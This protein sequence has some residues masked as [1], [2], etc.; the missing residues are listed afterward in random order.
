MAF[1]GSLW[2]YYAAN[3]VQ[4]MGQSKYGLVR[5]LLSKCVAPHMR[6]SWI[7]LYLK[8]KGEILESSLYKSS[9]L[10]AEVTLAPF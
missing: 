9:R 8:N 2:Q 1:S 7:C 6:I 4:F 10:V 3:G 5:S